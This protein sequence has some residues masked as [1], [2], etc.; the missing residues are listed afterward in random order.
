MTDWKLRF[1]DLRGGVASLVTL[2]WTLA[3]EP[4]TLEFSVP[5]IIPTVW[6]REIPLV[7][8]SFKLGMPL[9]NQ[10]VRR[11]PWSYLSGDGRLALVFNLIR[12]V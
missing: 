9:L 8:T 12:G 10:S 11:C 5:G 2:L 6:L 3:G 1:D 4:A 7:C